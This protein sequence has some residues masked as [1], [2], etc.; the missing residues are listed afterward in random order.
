MKQILITLSAIFSIIAAS[1]YAETTTTLEQR[2][3]NLEK[4]AP[5]LPAGVFINGEIELYIDPDSTTNKTETNA[6]IFIGLQNEIDHPVINWA[7]A[8]TRLDS[9]YSLNRTLDNTIVEKQLGFGIAGTRLYFGET[10]AQRLGFAKT[11]KIGAPLIITESSSRID[12]NEKIV[13]TYGG[14]QNSNEFEFDE[15]RLQRQLP[16]GVAIGY[17]P[18][19]EVM[20]AGA[21]VSL[22]GLAEVSYMRIAPETGSAQEGWSLGSQILRRY[23]I[24]VGFGIEVWDDKNTGT[25]TKDNRID[26]G[27]M[28]NVNKEFMLT[29]HRVENDDIGTDAMYYGALYTVGGIQTGIYLH[30]VDR[31]NTWT[32]QQ[33]E[34]ADSIKATIKY[35]F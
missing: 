13:L 21:T 10:D 28:Y 2:V 23:D 9:K 19:N 14:W 33:T 31:T 3:A 30:Q 8:S 27:V 24:P 26:I 6:E 12:H 32:G 34:Y 15:Y 4:S 17:D 7:G 5:S 25:Y 35:S 11:A 16:Y 20:Y 29:A 1:A 22:A 18:T